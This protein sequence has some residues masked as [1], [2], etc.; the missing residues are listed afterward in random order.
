MRFP[1]WRKALRRLPAYDSQP[2]PA[3]RQF[4][5]AQVSAGAIAQ[6]G[7]ALPE[8]RP[9]G[10]LP[11]TRWRARIAA[12]QAPWTL[13]ALSAVAAIA[14]ASRL[15]YVASFDGTYGSGDAQEDAM[16]VATA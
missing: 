3:R 1:F 13:L 8:V 16:R 12:L 10:A 7:L 2:A 11:E 6:G 4:V 15:R 14:L 5:W 9:A